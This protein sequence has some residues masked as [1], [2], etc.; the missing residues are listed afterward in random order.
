MA[1]P[2]S[3]PSSD[4]QVD[5]FTDAF[6][7]SFKRFGA[8]LLTNDHGISEESRK[9][10]AGD[11]A[12]SSVGDDFGTESRTYQATL[13]IFAQTQ[14]SPQEMWVARIMES[15]PPAPTDWSD[16]LIYL[17]KQHGLFFYHVAAITRDPADRSEI[18]AWIE[19]NVTIYHT[20]GYP[21]D[22]A[23]ATFDLG[24]GDDLV[25]EGTWPGQIANDYEAV[26]QDPGTNDSPLTVS[27]ESINDTN[28]WRLVVSLATDSSG[29]ITSTLQEIIDAVNTT[30]ETAQTFTMKLG[31]GG[32]AGDTASAASAITLSGGGASNKE[33]ISDL[34]SEA[35]SINSPRVKFYILPDNILHGFPDMVAFGQ[36]F[37]RSPGSFWLRHMQVSGIPSGTDSD[38]WGSDAW[39]SDDLQSIRAAFL[40]TIWT[41]RVGRTVWTD[42]F[43]TNE[44]FGDVQ[45]KVDRITID[46]EFQLVE[47]LSN[48]PAIHSGGLPYDQEGIDLIVE[49]TEFVLDRNSERDRRI[50]AR[51]QP[52]DTALFNVMAPDFEDVAGTTDHKNRI[53][54][55]T[56]EATILLFIGE[57]RVT[58]YLTVEFIEPANASTNSV[59]AGAQTE[60]VA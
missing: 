35:S 2:A 18:A 51:R 56:W 5:V 37:P 43:A 16:M 4:V 36:S 32:S 1:T 39:T 30:K 41:N 59:Q 45:Q 20:S 17:V 24:N 54:S 33:T 34:D 27:K 38:V 48:P 19:A 58:G 50:V 55:L 47:L 31:S 14:P 49:R 25:A 7:S 9:L 11:T 13:D 40:N 57:I 46:M 60:G 21:G 29:T 44:N 3:V 10:Y 28:N 52:D 53:Y 22:P 12:V 26:L 15:D 42:D 6:R 23:S 8:L